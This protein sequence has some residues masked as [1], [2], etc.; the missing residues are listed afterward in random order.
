MNNEATEAVFDSQADTGACLAVKAERQSLQLSAALTHHYWK[1]SNAVS[2]HKKSDLSRA[3]C[4]GRL[5]ALVVSVD[6]VYQ[7]RSGLL[8]REDSR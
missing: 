4:P 8:D 7:D 1:D 6:G 5:Y 2:Q 3:T